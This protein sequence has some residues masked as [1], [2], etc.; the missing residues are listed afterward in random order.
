VL[1]A[2]TVLCSYLKL[3]LRSNVDAMRQIFLWRVLMRFGVVQYLPW[4]S[5][6]NIVLC[7]A[8]TTDP[9]NDADSYIPIFYGMLASSVCFVESVSTF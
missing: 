7:W 8:V 3:Q 1:A 9:R 2:V 4:I 5:N 6:Q